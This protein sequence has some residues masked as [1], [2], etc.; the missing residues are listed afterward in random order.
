MADNLTAVVY[1]PKDFRLENLERPEPGE[2]EVQISVQSCGIC[3]TDVK[4][5]RYAKLTGLDIEMPFILGHE[6]SGIV[7][8]LGKE[9]TSLKLG[10]R[11]AAEPWRIC[12]YC[13]LCKSGNYNLCNV[14]NLGKCLARYVVLPEDFCH[15]IPEHIDFETA[16]LAEPLSV[17]IRICTR[18]GIKLGDHVLVLGSGTIGIF[19]MQTAKCMGAA[20]V[21]ITDCL[22]ERLV[23]AKRLGA[24]NTFL[25]KEQSIPELVDELAKLIGKKPDV[26]IE[27]AGAKPTIELGMKITKPTGC[28]LVAGLGPS[29]IE[30][31]LFETLLSEI[32]IRGSLAYTNN[33][34]RALNL[35]STGKVNIKGMITHR[36]PL[37]K[38]EDAMK[39]FEEN[40]KDLVKIIIDC[41]VE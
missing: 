37:E 12:R 7:T 13:D 33:Y 4:I 16:A 31:P 17:A 26:V 19:T 6:A 34:P 23:H 36:F 14:K 11:V 38:V 22:S 10:D 15:K 25:V 32:D 5:Y 21:T 35:L 29:R 41:S 3:A 2:K 40:P 28:L 1:G 30:I 8:K 20:S 9:V 39:L 18:A 27:C 24:D